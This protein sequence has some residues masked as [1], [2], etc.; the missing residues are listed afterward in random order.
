M[1]STQAPIENGTAGSTLTAR[2]SFSEFD[3]LLG[4][5]ESPVDYPNIGL[6]FSS[7][8]KFETLSVLPDPW[9][10][11]PREYIENREEMVVRNYAQYCSVVKTGI[12]KAK[13]II[14]GEVDASELIPIAMTL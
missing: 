1:P 5:V 13:M 14:G 12:G 7:G 2:D 11:T 10:P 6:I 4:H 9:D 3:E 8:Y